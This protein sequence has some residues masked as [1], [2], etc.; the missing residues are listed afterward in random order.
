M[1][2]IRLILALAVVLAH[3]GYG[4]YTLNSG[5]AVQ[6]FY[7]VSGFYMSLVLTDRY[8]SKAL[9]YT[10]RVLRIF[11]AYFVVLA[12]SLG[13]L[14]AGGAILKMDWETLTTV[15]DA[16][17]AVALVLTNL[18]IL[19]QDIICWFDV[20]DTGS[21]VYFAASKTDIQ[22]WRFLL[23][24]QAWTISLELMFYA[25]APFLVVMRTRTLLFVIVA[26]LAIRHAGTFTDIPYGI[27]PRRLF[28]GE[29]F[30]FLFGMLG[31]RSLKLLPAEA[32]K[33]GW[34]VLAGLLALILAQPFIPID[35]RISWAM[36]YVVV[37]AALPVLFLTF[38]RSTV[39]QA[40]GELSYPVYLVHILA[41]SA[42][43]TLG[44]GWRLP[45]I[46]AVTLVSAWALYW[47]VDRP[48]DRFRHKLRFRAAVTVPA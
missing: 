34:P 10:N 11:P 22:G 33:F 43:D 19:G 39:D 44:L 31:H 46:L 38:K 13:F 20:S 12:A 8:S 35:A 6:C 2:T 4:R 27:W 42:V 23:V 40:I 28:P 29:L 15:P 30:L 1:G 32:A 36:L 16:Q 18:F 37:A 47:L 3:A 14:W 45:T 25:L 9:F 24:P 41:I 26:S 48:V 7:I 5:L 17:A 21:L